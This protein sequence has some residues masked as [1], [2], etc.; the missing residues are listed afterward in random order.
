MS[1]L[2]AAGLSRTVAGPACR[3]GLAGLAG[4][5]VGRGDRPRPSSSAR[6][7]WS[8]P[9]ARN[10]ALEVRPAL[11]DEDRP[12][13]S[14]GD[15]GRQLVQVDALVAAAGDQDD[16][17][18]EG[19]QGGDDGIRLGALRVV[20]EPDAVDERDGLEPML[21]AGEAGGGLADGVGRDAE[22][23]RHGDRGQ[24]I[25]DVVVAGDGQLAD[26]HDPP[27]RP[28]R[29]DAATDQRQAR[30]ARPPRSSRPRPRRRPASAGRAGRGRAPSGA[31][32]A[33]PATTGSSAFRTSAPSGSTSSARRRLARR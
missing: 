7:V 4:H 15:D 10:S 32:S 14:L 27:A 5:R 26:R 16:R 23:Q 13:R 6:S 9:A 21:D 1:K 20:D 18:I 22:Q 17:A 29:G 31:R 11:T 19:A 12:G 3:P 28:G 30:D 2:A 25:R 8:R 33:N 24:R